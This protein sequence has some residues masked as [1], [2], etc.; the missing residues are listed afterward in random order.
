MGGCFGKSCCNE[1]ET[2]PT[3]ENLTS[4]ANSTANYEFQRIILDIPESGMKVLKQLDGFLTPDTKPGMLR[5]TISGI[6]DTKPEAKFSRCLRRSQTVKVK[7]FFLRKAK[8]KLSL[9]R[10]DHNETARPPTGAHTYRGR[11]LYFEDLH[12]NI[13]DGDKECDFD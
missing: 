7:E 3:C 6:S 12:I 9:I 11:V 5:R 2:L 4:R 8:K 13:P 1:R 10:F